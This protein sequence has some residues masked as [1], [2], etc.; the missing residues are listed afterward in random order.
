[1]CM[2]KNFI[3]LIIILAVLSCGGKSN[4]AEDKF[5]KT[6]NHIDSI[7]SLYI[8]LSKKYDTIT[9]LSKKEKILQKLNE[10]YSISMNYLI[11]S[12]DKLSETKYAAKLA[13]IYLWKFRDNYTYYNKIINMLNKSPMD[14]LKSLLLKQYKE[15]KDEQITGEAPQFSLPDNNNN[16]VNLKDYIGSYVLVDF[17]ASWCAPCR[18]QNKQL[19]K[20]YNK[21]K[22]KGLVVI[23]ISMDTDYLLWKKAL[24]EDN[25]PW[26]QLN[27]S[28]GFK[29]SKLRQDY[30]FQQIPTLFLIDKKGFI[31]SKNPSHMEIL[32]IISEKC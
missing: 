11:G 30:K 14:S 3:F 31:I 24:E 13:H 4:I 23:S 17:W 10:Q 1:M 32:D 15:I 25:L 28:V 7:D 12:I 27:D 22:T 26:I 29:A 8:D 20:I 16:T 6:L 9:A 2:I 19:Y 21:L 18:M 5:M